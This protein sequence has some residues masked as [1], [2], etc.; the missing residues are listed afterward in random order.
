MIRLSVRRFFLAG[1]L[2]TAASVCEAAAHK[3]CILNFDRPD[4]V[5]LQ[6]LNRKVAELGRDDIYNGLAGARIEDLNAC[7]R[8]GFENI[9]IFS[10]G[11][12]TNEDATRAALTYF[13]PLSA[14]ERDAEL[15]AAQA[16]VDDM[17][18]FEK[19]YHDYP[20]V[21]PRADP[22]GRAYDMAQAKMTEAKLKAIEVN[23]IQGYLPIQLLPIF[24]HTQVIPM[25]QQTRALHRIVFVTCLADPVQRYYQKPFAELRNL[26]VQIDFQKNSSFLSWWYGEQVVKFDETETLNEIQNILNQP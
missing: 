15:K 6:N 24:F 11:L 18:A 7:V 22:E 9:L 2:L 17:H 20:I 10:H 8:S 1:I 14:E 19:K 25:V 16:Q 23:N 12:P 4:Q 5:P 13:V 3:L 26:G 21:G